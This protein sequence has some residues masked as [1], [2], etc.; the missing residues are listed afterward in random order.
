MW[1]IPLG[2][3]IYSAGIVELPSR[4]EYTTVPPRGIVLKPIFP[5]NVVI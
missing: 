3:R 1:S 5:N 2:I 4:L